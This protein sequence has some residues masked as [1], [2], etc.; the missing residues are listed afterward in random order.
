MNP[1]S[2]FKDRPPYFLKHSLCTVKML[3]DEL[4]AHGEKVRPAATI[5]PYRSIVEAPGL[6]LN[7]RGATALIGQLNTAAGVGRAEVSLAIIRRA[8]NRNTPTARPTRPT[9]PIP[10]AAAPQKKVCPAATI[11]PDSL[12]AVAPG[13]ALDA[14]GT[15]ALVRHLY[16]AAGI[17]PA[18][19]P[20]AVIG[21]TR[22]VSPILCSDSALGPCSGCSD[23]QALEPEQQNNPSQLLHFDLS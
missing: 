11:H 1:I 19:M 5:D 6:A 23:G 8:G 21:S 3:L 18:Q 7:A 16:P 15:A 20:L 14:R 17:D 9:G 22:H 12:T 2:G 4:S 13:L 10:R